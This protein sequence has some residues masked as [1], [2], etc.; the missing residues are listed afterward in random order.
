MAAPTVHQSTIAT[1]QT[2][3][4]GALHVTVMGPNVFETFPLPARGSVRIGRDEQAEVRITDDLASRLHARID[5]DG[6]AELSVEDL[7]SSNG[8]FVRGERIEPGQRIALQPGE[9]VTIGYTHLMVQHRRAPTAPRRF[10]GHGAFEERLED[11]CARAAETGTPLAVLRVQLGNED[12]PGRGAELLA[13][14]L[15]PGD[16]L[17]QYAPGDY[18]ILL[19]DT[20]P[21]RAGAL[22][23]EAAR[24]VRAEGLDA[25]AVVATCPADGRS[26]E[27]LIGRTSAL[28]RGN[29]GGGD[30]GREPVLKSETMRQLYRLAGLAASGQTASGLI[31]VL[32]LGETGAGKE[33]LADWIHRHSPRARGPL[34][35]I[36]CAALTD[37]LLESELFG[38]EKGAFTGAV[39]A[40]PGLL[41]AAAG[42][43]VFLD[44]IGEMPGALQTKLLRALEGRQIT[45]VGGLAPRTIDVRFVAATNRDLETEVIA[46]T[47]R[48]DLY[49]R[50]NGISLTIPPLR[51]RPEEIEP[52]ARRFLEAAAGAAK[53]RPPRLAPEALE[54]LRAYS[55]PGNIRE[56]RNVVE[57]ALVFAEGNE[58]SAEH[59]PV[60]KMRL[61]R[62][63][64]VLA[65]TAPAPLPGVVDP[66][67]AGPLSP[68]EEA[69]YRRIVAVLAEHGF[70][71][72]R[73]AKALGMARG[74]LIQ[75]MKR[76]GIKGP[77]GP[78]G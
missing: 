15:R 64:P 8:T 21:A 36:N 49:F 20:D 12:P 31:N 78:R 44:E 1:R 24:R 37:T 58:I 48:Q 67:A 74:T 17:G 75:R 69:E 7:G 41:E 35:C 70:N 42:G 29:D 30:G 54:S 60:E 47:F 56:L 43:T 62:L 73:A 50:L 6:A 19:Y 14:A 11:A 28:L 39:Q 13:N 45:R 77:Q 26:A 10:H 34:V 38:Y 53:R 76:Y 66:A 46:K 61:S 72:T 22:A 5:V 4:G 32:I 23:E 27:A 55:W 2:G 51:E 18:E 40:K 9:A 59:L 68:G 3:G 65:P 63:S 25:R 33:V 71:Q 57:R 16:F 52:L